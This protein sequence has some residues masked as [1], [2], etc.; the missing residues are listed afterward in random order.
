MAILLTGN[1]G[2]VKSI[3]PK[4][5]R[6]IIAVMLWQQFLMMIIWIG[7]LAFEICKIKELQNISISLRFSFS[8][9]HFQLYL[10]LHYFLQH[11]PS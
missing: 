3:I 8:P 10:Y 9:S 11:T 7:G 1:S 6:E 2:A 4:K 5:T